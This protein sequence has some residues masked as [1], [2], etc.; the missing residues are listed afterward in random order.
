MRRLAR[1]ARHVP[2]PPYSTN[3]I[4][5]GIKTGYNPAFIVDGSTRDCLV[6][7]DPRSAEILKP[8]LRGRDIQ[9]YR[10]EWAELWLI[11]TLPSLNIDID[12]YPAVKRHLL[13]YGRERLA[14]T[15]TPLPDGRRSRKRTP[16]R[17]FEL[18]D[19]CAYHAEFSKPRLFW[20]D[21]SPQGRFAYSDEEIYCND[22]A[23]VMTGRSLKWLCAILNSHIV[24]WMI[25]NT[26]RTTGAGLTQWQKFVVET[27][28]VPRSSA[29]DRSPVVDRIDQMLRLKAAGSEGDTTEL[30]RHLDHLIYSL[31]GLTDQEI[32]V[33]GGSQD[34]A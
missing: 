26:A 1:C 15:G 7:E 9:R 17:W 20:M 10:A 5:Y 22:K 32:E 23:Y 6:E 24:T 16:H 3:A 31:Y 28:P 19:T 27:I 2:L 14:Q 34:N 8:I 33:V 29:E 21:M 30:E 18:Q 4:Y 12:A 13:S 11:S 25:R